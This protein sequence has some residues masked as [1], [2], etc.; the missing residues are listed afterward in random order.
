LKRTQVVKKIELKNSVTQLEK[1]RKSLTNRMDQ[2]ENTIRGLKDEYRLLDNIKKNINFL[3]RNM[4][5]IWDT[6][7]RLNFQI[8]GIDEVEESKVNGVN[9]RKKKNPKLRKNILIQIQE[10]HGNIK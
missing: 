5:E 4:E 7:N 2:V 1:S 10:A 9:H 3:K 6:M 8:I